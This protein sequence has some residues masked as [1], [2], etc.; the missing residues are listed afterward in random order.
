M[1]H[2]RP[3]ESQTTIRKPSVR[4]SRWDSR[5]G[6]VARCIDT[7]GGTRMGETAGGPGTDSAGRG[8][9]H[10]F[11]RD[12]RRTGESLWT[13]SAAT[14]IPVMIVRTL[15]VAVELSPQE[16]IRARAQLALQDTLREQVQSGSQATNIMAAPPSPHF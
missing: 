9:R 5:F 4:P 11:D 2:T 8:S 14:G 16:H 12:D 13:A 7:A 10:E 3:T 15:L 1:P 6:R